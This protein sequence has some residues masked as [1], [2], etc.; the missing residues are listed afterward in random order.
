MMNQSDIVKIGVT[1]SAG[2]GKSLVLKAFASLGLVTLDCDQIA[3]QVVLPGQKGYAGVV[4]IFGRQVVKPD[5]TLDRSRLRNMMV[6]QPEL[7][8]QLETLLHPLIFEALFHQINTAV[9]GREKA[10][11]VEVPLLF[12]TGMQNAFD[13]VV[14]VAAPDAVLAKRIA[15]RDGVDLEDAKKMLS[16]QMDQEKKTAQSDHVIYNQGVPGEVFESVADMYAEIKKEFLTR[17]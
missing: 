2:S 3:R 10:C 11:A 17:K 14:T 15:E 12:E 4:K 16:L 7:R 13:V 9:Y 6:D 1:G 8:R 5:K